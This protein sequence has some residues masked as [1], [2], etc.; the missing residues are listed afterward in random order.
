MA[1]LPWYLKLVEYDKSSSYMKFKVRN[2]YVGYLIIANKIN[3]IKKYLLKTFK[4][5]VS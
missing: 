3:N 5:A 2:S 1:K 4:N